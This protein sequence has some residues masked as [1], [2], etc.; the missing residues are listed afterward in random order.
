MYCN[1]METYVNFI[2]KNIFDYLKSIQE[3]NCDK[4]IAT[5][6]TKTYINTRYYGYGL[7][8]KE[9]SL[10][11]CIFN[12]LKLQY[13][14]LNKKFPKKEKIIQD[15]FY[16]FKYIF[17][18][19]GIKKDK[20]LDEIVNEISTRR[21]K[22]YNLPEKTENTFKTKF[23]KR[24]ESDISRKSKFLENFNSD[25]FELIIEPNENI[26]NIYD[27]TI[28]S[29][30]KFKDIYR[31]DALE[32]VFNSGMV[33]EDKLIVE[34]SLMATHIT[35][36]ILD[37][38]FEKKYLI[39]Y[40]ISLLDKKRKNKQILNI[41]D[42]EAIQNKL[43]FKITYKQF[44]KNR[45]DIYDLMKRGYKFA[46]IINKD[47]NIDNTNLNMFSFILLT[48]EHPKKNKYLQKLKNVI[49]TD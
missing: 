42:N 9:K 8:K 3:V 18:I 25:K 14:E 39:N 38:N 28:K 10:S 12:N 48:N 32:N 19:E 46:V 13:D 44:I 45:Y 1:I 34:Y 35:R 2:E 22:K 23:K 5:E 47:N 6:L 33:A 43:I 27:V 16:L 15:T 26:K 41:L 21:V 7:E 31:E 11:K 49:I 36:D 29:N 24:V 30:I 17:Y 40:T 20:S 4:K 37:C